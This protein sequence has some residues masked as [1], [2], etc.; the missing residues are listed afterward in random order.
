MSRRCFLGAA[1]GAGVAGPM[2]AT[3]QAKQ[4]PKELGEY[5]DLAALRP[6]PKVKILGAVIRQ[7]PPYWLGWPG[8][9][10]DLEGHRKEYERNFGEIAKHLG[11]GFEMTDPPLESDE[12]V[13][14][15][16][17]RIQ[18]E[19]P[20]AVLVHIQH[21]SYW[22]W[23]EAI[24]RAGL[25]T[26][27]FSPVGTSFTHHT[28]KIS[29]QP[30]VHVISSLC[31]E[32]VEQAFRMVRAKRQLEESRVLVVRGEERKET[33]LERLGTKVRY[34]PRP[35]LHELFEQMPA[36]DEA[37]DIARKMQRQAEKSVE[38]NREDCVNAA[39]SFL[40]AKRLVKDEASNA[41]TTD[42]LGMVTSRL[43]PTPPCMAATIF[44]DHG[45]TYGCE[46]DLF[47]AISLM[48]VSYLFDKPG[49]M[50]DPV[51]ETYKN[52]L[53]GAHCTSAT[54]LNGFDE[55][56]EPV[57]LR[58][59]SESDIGVATQVLWKEGQPITLLR[60]Q[61]PNSLILDTGTVVGNVQTPP[62]GGCRTSVEVVMDRMEDARDVI[63]FHQ[64][65]FYGNHRRDVEAFCQMYGIK[66]VNS[67][68]RG[69][70]EAIS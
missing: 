29:R 11:I 28:L 9:S 19:K 3:A 17:N 39:R 33:V 66:V 40:T 43:V 42:C 34:V 64:V 32:P 55:D 41:I 18:A 8:T 51:A 23:A 65:F 50:Q 36:T 5:V 10:Y 7:K 69:P 44:Q 67:P 59:H 6:R 56:P 14:A 25:P 68:E 21:L 61:D 49:F 2:L 22:R 30:K 63:G 37:Q 15:F 60:F 1:A 20:D 12:A 27:I 70:R 4:D 47:A 54:R 58:S 45:V 16:V 53:I 62:A 38:P 48:C 52:L 46:A 31:L 26:I 24:T 35:S 13:N 57:I